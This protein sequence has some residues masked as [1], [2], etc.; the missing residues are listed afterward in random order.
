MEKLE[1]TCTVHG[2]LEESYIYKTPNKA[3]RLGYYLRCQ[4]C[5]DERTWKYGAKQC[6]KHG[7]LKAGDIKSDGR[8]AI[9]HRASANKKRDDNRDWFNEKLAKDRLENPEKW[10]ARYKKEYQQALGRPGDRVLS[11][12][13][14]M[15]KLTHKQ[16][17]AMLLEQESLC[18]ICRKPETRKSRTPGKI[19][20]L[21]VDHCHETNQVRGLLCHNCNHMLGCALDDIHILEMGI[22]YLNS[23]QKEST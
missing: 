7:T 15:H 22:L 1:Y 19:A 8:C 18:K 2:E 23:F 4:K 10:E 3:Y 11:E 5:I 17:E 16:Y 20:R 9:C 12:I 6:K 21:V 14:R 13:L